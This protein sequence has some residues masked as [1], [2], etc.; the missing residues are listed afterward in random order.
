MKE[1]LR[2]IKENKSWIVTSSETLAMGAWIIFV[3]LMH[4]RDVPPMLMAFRPPYMP[5]IMIVIGLYSLIVATK[6]INLGVVLGNAF[7][8]SFI[9]ISSVLEA[10]TDQTPLIVIPGML[11]IVSLG[12]LWR[13]FSG[14][15]KIEI[16]RKGHE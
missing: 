5:W 16:E 12:I 11:A 8:W 3:D 15:S 1:L 13:I 14:A 4:A 7:V 10:V 9:A 2:K 6:T